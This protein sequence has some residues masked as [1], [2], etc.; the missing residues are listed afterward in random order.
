MIDVARPAFLW[1]G[2]LLAGLPALLHL[3][4]P[5]ERTKKPL[6]TLRFLTPDPRRRVHL[7][8]TPDE[9]PLLLL[10]MLLCLVLGAAFSG[11]SW[12]GRES[13]TGTIVV[14]DGGAAMREVWDEARTLAVPGAGPRIVETLVVR[15]GPLGG[16]G[17]PT[18]AWLG[19]S[20]TEPDS[21]RWTALA[22]DA[23]A[24]D[25]RLA[26]LL[27]ALRDAAA[28]V[29]GVD[30]LTARIVTRPTWGA[31]G[32]GTR[33]LRDS[34][35]PGAIELVTPPPAAGPDEPPG[36]IPVTLFA[37]DL[38]ARVAYALDQVGFFVDSASVPSADGAEVVLRV[39]PADAIGSLWSV[40]PDTPEGD[41]DLDALLLLDGRV[42]PG[43]GAAPAGIPAEDA[44]VPLLRIG[45]RPAAAARSAPGRCE[46]A[47]PLD[48]GA[49][50]IDSGNLAMVLEATLRAACPFLPEPSGADA[51]WRALLEGSADGGAVAVRGIRGEGAGLPL[52]R[53]LLGLAL[54]L[55]IME[56]RLTRTLEAG[57]GFDARN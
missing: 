20:A 36:P 33:E 52:A 6:P 55:G 46:V 31:W 53:W 26:H 8:R 28:V 10:R 15:S 27:R 22:P 23:S 18:L 9:V 30:S 43:A 38:H 40:G 1:A 4:R 7:R 48:E 56:T 12:V 49:A 42:V 57:R 54:L 51:A 29:T 25:V 45:G 39:G 11:M 24:G 5:R 41:P 35:W 47:V 2:V 17:V 19:T 14:V 50:I 13:G 32:P 44:T 34:L 21:D 3:L 16:E 37:G